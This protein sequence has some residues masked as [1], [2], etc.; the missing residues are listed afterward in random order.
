MDIQADLSVCVVPDMED[1]DLTPCVESIL[2]QNDPVLLEIFLPHGYGLE[3]RFADRPEIQFV[4]YPHVKHGDNVYH[5]WQQATGRY[6]AVVYSSVTVGP[7]SFLGMLEFLDDHPD[8]GAA[9]PRLFS[10]DNEL[11][12]NCFTRTILPFSSPKKMNGWDGRT[13][14]EVDWMSPDALFVNQMAFAECPAK[15]FAEKIWTRKLCTHLKVK[16]WHQFFVHYSKGICHSP[17]QTAL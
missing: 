1:A 12:V 11:Q 13:S 6:L 7:G 5:V 3:S 8:V 10:T 14:L 16:G 4:D 2:A 15:V 17:L 9:A